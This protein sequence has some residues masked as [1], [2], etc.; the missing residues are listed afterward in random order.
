MS[1]EEL[2]KFREV[3]NLKKSWYDSC[4]QNID[5][6]CGK[7]INRYMEVH[8]EFLKDNQ[9]LTYSFDFE[10]DNLRIK[11]TRYVVDKLLVYNYIDEVYLLIPIWYTCSPFIDCVDQVRLVDK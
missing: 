10:G 2:E 4:Y 11:C 6:W 7:V 8:P 1:R 9:K 3:M 5:Q